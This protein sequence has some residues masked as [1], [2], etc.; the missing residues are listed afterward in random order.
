MPAV[1]SN[2]TEDKQTDS[3]VR[4]NPDGKLFLAKRNTNK[5]YY[6]LLR[7]LAGELVRVQ[8]L[9]VLYTNEILPDQ[10]NAFLSEWEKVVGIPDACFDGTGSNKER[11]DKILA[12]LN[13]GVQTNADFVNIAKTAFDIDITVWAGA[14]VVNGV[15]GAPPDI[16]FNG[17]LRRA[18]FGIVITF[19]SQDNPVFPLVFPIL[20]G[21]Q[22]LGIMTCFIKKLVPS[23]CEV[24]FTSLASP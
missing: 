13:S 4:Y 9:L 21:A 6:K 11:R 23:N 20:F 18:R 17:E 2:F 12:K 15:G 3:L 16:Y 5:N 22:I 7:G 14:D 24:F 8:D 1:F 10:T 19:E